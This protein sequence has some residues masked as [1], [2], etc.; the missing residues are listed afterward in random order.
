MSLTLMLAS[1]SITLAL[2]LYTIGVFAERSSRSLRPIHVLMF[3]CGLA[4]DSTGTALMTQMARQGEAG[5]SP[6][7]GITGALAIALMLFHAAWAL[8]TLLR[9]DERALEGF[10][11]L[12]SL[13]WLAWLVPYLIGLLMG[14]PMLALPPVAAAS[15]SLIVVL[16]LWRT[17]LRGSKA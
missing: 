3:W 7:H 2:V 10:H 9:H 16:A 1:G 5:I 4:F 12:S 8:V 15:V 17:L 6:V 13:V 14:M 11:R